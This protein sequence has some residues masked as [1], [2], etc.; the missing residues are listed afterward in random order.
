MSY[1][2]PTAGGRQSPAPPIASSSLFHQVNNVVSSQTPHSTPRRPTATTPKLKPQTATSTPRRAAQTDIAS[3]I[4]ASSTPAPSGYSL[5]SQP[6]IPI[7]KPPTAAAAAAAFFVHVNGAIDSAA[8]SVGGGGMC[9]VRYRFVHGVDWSIVDG[10]SDAIS[11]SAKTATAR[12]TSDNQYADV[13]TFNLPIAVTF[14]STN[15]SDWPRLVVSVYVT[16]EASVFHS[17]QSAIDQCVGVGWTFVPVA[18]T[19]NDTRHVRLTRPVS[20]SWA[21]WILSRISGRAPEFFDS[22]FVAQSNGRDV[23]RTQSSGAVSVTFTT[24]MQNMKRHGYDIDKT[25]TQHNV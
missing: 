1:D 17:A 19:S 2:T 12:T 24:K 15:V 23:T 22:A 20:S 16:A 13:A 25:T 6:P 7:H 4:A 3:P 10:V 5:V 11:Q 9:Y 8:L 14:R 18:V 21:H